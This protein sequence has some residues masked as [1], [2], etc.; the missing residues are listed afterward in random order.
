[1]ATY[2]AGPATNSA[3]TDCPNNPGPGNQG[4]EAHV[5]GAVSGL[6]PLHPGRAPIVDATVTLTNV[7]G[8]SFTPINSNYCTPS[9]PGNQ[10]LLIVNPA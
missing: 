1:M 3:V 9:G 5:G 6:N 7:A 2:D 10:T 4:I 8:A